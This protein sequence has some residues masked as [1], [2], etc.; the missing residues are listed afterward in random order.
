MVLFFVK[1]YLAIFWGILYTGG[2]KILYYKMFILFFALLCY[3]TGAF[4]YVLDEKVLSTKNGKCSINYLSDKNTSGW[5][6]DVADSGCRDENALNG[7]YSVVVYNG[8]AEQVDQLTGYFSEGYFTNDAF[9]N[10]PLLARSSAQL[11]VQKAT[12]YIEKDMINEIDYIGQMVSYNEKQGGYSPFNVCAP[13]RV[14]AVTNNVKAFDNFEEY[15]PVFENI[16]KMAGR[17][18]SQTNKTQLFVSA[19]IEPEP[20]DI[21]FFAE[22]DFTPD[23]AK[24]S[25]IDNAE[26]MANGT[27]KVKYLKLPQ[28][29]QQKELAQLRTS[30][31][32]R[33]SQLQEV[34][35]TTSSHELNK[36]KDEPAFM[37]VGKKDLVDNIYDNPVENAPYFDENQEIIDDDIPAPEMVESVALDT[38]VKAKNQRDNEKAQLL[39]KTD[40]IVP[41]STLLVLSKMKKNPVLGS[42]IV[43][44][45]NLGNRTIIDVDEPYLMD[46]KGGNLS[47]GWY[48]IK[49]YYTS[50]VEDIVRDLNFY[51]TVDVVN[52]TRCNE[53]YCKDKDV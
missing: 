2:M 28:T 51:G 14:L 11:G 17:F 41:V 1:N 32:D 40:E 26:N 24:V 53:K 47:D 9:V 13:F 20:A 31:N 27:K 18:C 7:Y 49:G 25:V 36:Y 42:A 8:F 4:G 5:F 39:D 30:L 44:V 34:V 3:G 46:I 38:F 23:S 45:A 19:A 22:I 33:L 6:I 12:F 50:K 37:V 52:A 10:V 48:I 21:V 35:P 16:R 43:H 15:N 29:S